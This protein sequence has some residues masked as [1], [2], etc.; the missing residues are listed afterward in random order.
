MH[1]RSKNWHF[2]TKAIHAGQV[3]EDGTRSVT[4]AIYPSST[5]RVQFPGDESGY[6]YSRWMNPTR[7][8]LEDA[9][10]ALENGAKAAAF[11]SGLS[12]LDSVLKLLKAGDH[13]VAVD[14]LYGGTLRQFERIARNF[15]LDFTYVDGRDPAN[16]EKAIK[17]NT[18]LI[19][20]ETPTNPLLHLTDIEKVVEIAKGKKH[21]G[22]RGQHLR[23]AVYPETARPW[24]RHCPAQHVQVP[25]RPLRHYRRRVDCPR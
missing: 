21:S 14:D 15:N 4:T 18:R 3:P 2:E 6:V 12:A 17:D 23:H 22:R 7:K 13:I 1:D 19:W 10:A 8:A 16:F 9:L 5:Y 24:R 11:S 20:L 25:R